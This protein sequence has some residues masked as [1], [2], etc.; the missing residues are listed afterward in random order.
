MKIFL[1]FIFSLLSF[2]INASDGLIFKQ[3]KNQWPNKV[4][5]GAEIST[6][7]IFIEKNGLTWQLWSAEDLYKA[8]N[9]S[10]NTEANKLDND[11]ATEK[12]K[13]HNYKVE[14]INAQFANHK[15]FKQ[16]PEYY[17][18]FL[19][20][21]PH[22]WASKVSAYEELYFNN[23][24]NNIDVKYYS[25]NGL[26]KYDFIIK[27][28]GDYNAILLDYKFVD[29][30]YLKNE[31]L[32]IKTT[33]GTIT[34]S[35]PEAY[36]LI[37][38]KKVNVN[39]KYKLNKNNIVSFF[40]EENY[41]KE[42]D[43][44][45]D[46]SVVVASFSGTQS[47]TY[48]LG[49][50]YDAKGSIFLYS[51]NITKNYPI[52]FGA[53]QTTFAGG[54][55]DCTLSKFNPTG[56]VKFFST[57]IGGNKSEFIVNSVVQNGE[58]TLFGFTN[59][60]TMPILNNGFQPT[61]GGGNNDYFII[62]LDT[63]GKTLLAS[64]YIGG[65]RAEAFITIGNSL[66]YYNT[67]RSELILDVQNN[68]YFIG[69]TSSLNFPT[70]VGCINP[71]NDSTN[72]GNLCIVKLNKNLNQ[73]VWSTY[74]GGSS[75]EEA[76]GL[77]LGKSGNLYCLGSTNSSNFP[78]TVGVVYPSKIVTSDMVL[79]S[80][81]ATT[82]SLVAATYLGSKG[83]DVALGIDL[84]LNENIYVYG[85]TSSPQT[86]TC[87]PGAYCNSSGNI[88]F[89]KLKN[90]LSQILIT[91]KFGYTSSNGNKMEIDAFNIDSCG[92]IYFGGFGY[93]GLPA[94][95]NAFK[96]STLKGNL[97][98]GIFNPNFSS[99]KYASYY[100]SDLLSGIYDFD[101]DDGGLNYFDDN[102]YFY[103]GFC[104]SKYF[105][106]TSNGYSPIF[107]VNDSTNGGG[108]YYYSRS[109]GFVK[110]DLQT[111]VNATSTLGGE[112]KSCSPI[113]ATFIASTNLG[114]VSIIPGD[115]SPAVVSNSLIYTYSNYGIY[116]AYVIAGTD[117]ST[118]NQTDSIKTVIKYGP[119][120]KD[121][122]SDTTIN[123]IGLKMPL[124]AKNNG[125]NYLWNTGQTS[126]I[127]IP[128]QSAMYYVNI[129]NG[130]CSR[131]DSSYL[132]IL[133]ILYPMILPNIITPNNDNVND[134]WDFSIYGLAD[135][136]FIVFNRWGTQVYKTSNI[137]D[138]WNG[139]NQHGQQLSEGTYFWVINFKSNCN[140]SERIQQ[141]G[142]IQIVR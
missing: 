78:T 117:T 128:L 126:Q 60:D 109:D 26:F 47:N 140:V 42:Y 54:V 103:H 6:G 108:G 48:G 52:T 106:T 119:P 45:I 16:Q 2:F 41:N 127:I 50:T 82:G 28:G 30:L 70:T 77:R 51:L 116:N 64:T 29:S 53:I 104:V 1:L 121:A 86:V 80:I 40:V 95:A 96:S 34:E 83:S 87:T 71:Y 88:I 122:L 74:Y 63:S 118:C 93:N 44:I 84:D 38:G 142:Y 113:T 32:Y 92:Y 36:Q 66:S 4:L 112:L 18:Y 72:Y 120:P 65:S 89:F 90:D 67:P 46:P 24:Y 17:N 61:Y 98:F 94:T 102:G 100:G 5:Y 3:N 85:S 73:L 59:S 7:Q 49:T 10:H 139:I 11:S 137:L 20:N 37:N 114:T 129:D 12:I 91:S 101:H 39:C 8:H 110:I 125:S 138:K 31:K 62:K 57:Y 135:L 134:Y 115:G 68:C 9:H 131:I 43:L 136:E 76:T 23:V 141:K 132:K 21:N 33:V 79:V 133:P 27:K 130:Y 35:I 75:G 19:G 22:Q 14:F 13:G 69:N 123:C 56:T 105:P 15:T 81:N 111:F 99:L 58:I 25:N 107:N 55:L 97:Y 124:D